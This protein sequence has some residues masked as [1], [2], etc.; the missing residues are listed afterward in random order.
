M[1][2][3]TVAKETGTAIVVLDDAQVEAALRG[4]LEE[5]EIQVTIED[6]KQIQLDIIQRILASEDADS[7]FGGQQAIGGKEVLG[8]PFTLRGVRWHKS[9]F[10][11]GLPVFAVLDALFLDGEGETLAVTTS[12]GNVMAQAFQLHKLGS[13]PCDVKIDEADR[14]TAAGFRPQWL[15]RA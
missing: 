14:E 2:T 10:D 1:A 15:V 13:L 4:E 5:S 7:V 11:A 8:R 3:E 6:P 9:R 12:S